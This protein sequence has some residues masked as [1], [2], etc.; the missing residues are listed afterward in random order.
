MKKFIIT[1]L[2]LLTFSLTFAQTK[3]YVHPDADSYV[4]DTN[5]MAILPLEVQVKLRP[6][7]LKDFTPEQIVEMQEA[8]AIDIQRGMY[9]WFLKRKQRGQ[10]KFDVLSIAKTN[11]ELRKAGIDIHDL[12]LYAP[13][14]LGKI[15]NVDVVIMGTF[16]TSKP[17]SNAAGAALALLGGAFFSTQTAVA[18][19]DFYNTSDDELVVNYYKKVSGSIGSDAQDLINVLMRKVTRRIPYTNT[20]L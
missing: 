8:E 12:S 4:A 10:L 13:S 19:M 16:E 15:L 14:D 3:L 2:A 18:N 9:S 7:Q 1:T 6:R 17:M 5:S 20:K 11:A